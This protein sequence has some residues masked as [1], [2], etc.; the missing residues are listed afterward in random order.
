M[1]LNLLSQ[2][3]Y[4]LSK[5][6]VEAI[7]NATDGKGLAII[8]DRWMVMR[9]FPLP[10][11]PARKPIVMNLLSQKHYSLSEEEV[12]AICN[13]TD[14]KGLVIIYTR[15]AIPLPV[16]EGPA[17]KQIVLNLLSQQ[18]YSLSEEDG[19]V[20]KYSVNRVTCLKKLARIKRGCTKTKFLVSR[21]GLECQQ[22]I[23]LVL[24]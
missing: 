2:Q 1:V 20:I 12:E 18:H 8:Y 11:G 17:R 23:K 21:R 10:E 15:G 19:E 4:S 7:C 16:L 9:Y 3:H 22:E 14:G 5:E 13:A 24:A 6:E